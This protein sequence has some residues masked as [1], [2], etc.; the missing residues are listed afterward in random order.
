MEKLP[1]L[2]TGCAA[3]ALRPL[4]TRETAPEQWGGNMKL[5]NHH[6]LWGQVELG[7][8]WLGYFRGDFTSLSLSRSSVKGGLHQDLPHLPGFCEEEM[9]SAR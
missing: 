6:Q 5:R 1:G 2:Q 4:R 7:R 8:A 9:G 3:T